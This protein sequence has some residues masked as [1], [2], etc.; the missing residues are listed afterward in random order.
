MLW[1]HYYKDGKKR[2]GRQ[3][4]QA[5]GPLHCSRMGARW[6][7]TQLLVAGVKCCPLSVASS[8]NCRNNFTFLVSV[9]GWQPGDL[10]SR[11]VLISI[12]I[13]Y[14]IF[15]PR[16]LDPALELTTSVHDYVQ[17]QSTHQYIDRRIILA[18]YLVRLVASSFPTKWK[19]SEIWGI[20]C[21]EQ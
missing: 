4:H 9:T 5:T 19:V 21:S 12:A 11:N 13:I 8:Q 2:G 6:H 17:C 18:W 16:R 7:L 10:E 1:N 3:P 20:Y 15:T 14:S